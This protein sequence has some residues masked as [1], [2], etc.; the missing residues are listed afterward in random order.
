MGT[1]TKSF[2]TK[3]RK[4]E[5]NETVIDIANERELNPKEVINEDS[6]KWHL[7]VYKKESLFSKIINKIKRILEDKD[8]NNK[9][10]ASF[11]IVW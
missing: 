8:E 11:E 3:N 10:E 2:Q 5:D 9:A 1:H 4:P 7:V 6:G